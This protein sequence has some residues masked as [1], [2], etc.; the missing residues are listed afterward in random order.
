MTDDCQ[1]GTLDVRHS[2]EPQTDKHLDVR[3]PG[4]SGLGNQTSATVF[5]H[6]G[7]RRN[8]TYIRGSV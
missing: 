6:G 2:Q 3:L 1:W 8:A 4:A 5:G 7:A